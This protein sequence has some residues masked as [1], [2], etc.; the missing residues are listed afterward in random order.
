M[1]EGER[2]GAPFERAYRAAQ[3]FALILMPV[4]LAVIGWVTQKSITETAVRKDYVQMALQV[5]REPRKEDDEEIRRFARE[6]INANSPVQLSPEAAGQLSG[7]LTM[8]DNHPLL[9]PAMMKRPGC[10]KVDLQAIPHDQ[11][12]AVD[13]LHRQCVKNYMDLFWIQIYLNMLRNPEQSDPSD[14]D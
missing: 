5:L 1:N 11:V 4:A 3:I 2:S 8:L 9:T 12:E 10:S 13:A 14:S 6:I 7:S